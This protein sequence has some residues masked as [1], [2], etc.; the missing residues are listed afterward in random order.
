MQNGGNNNIVETITIFVHRF[1]NRFPLRPISNL[2]IICFPCQVS[3][4]GKKD[5]RCF[6]WDLIREVSRRVWREKFG[7]R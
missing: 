3:K 5:F 1:S 7:A 4:V 2:I 6:S